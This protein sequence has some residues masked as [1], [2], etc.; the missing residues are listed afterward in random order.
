MKFKQNQINPSLSENPTRALTEAPF[1]NPEVIVPVT[2]R[3]RLTAGYKLQILKE[4]DLCKRRPGALGALLRKEGLYSSHLN[5]WNKQRDAGILSAFS[6]KRGR[7]QRYSSEEIK[8]QRLTQ[9]NTQLQERLRQAE[10]IVE[11]Q[12]KVSTILGIPTVQT[13]INS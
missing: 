7:K 9:E 6:G 8:I 5:Q 3:R 11:I 10:L 2:K 1:P 13:E 12:K 4:A